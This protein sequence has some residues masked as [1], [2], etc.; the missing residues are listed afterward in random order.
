MKSVLLQLRY[1][2]VFLMAYMTSNMSRPCCKFVEPILTLWA[3][4]RIKEI[5]EFG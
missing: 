3:K 4:L 5:G 2:M 1:L